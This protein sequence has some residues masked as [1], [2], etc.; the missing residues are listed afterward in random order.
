MF[1]YKSLSLI[2]SCTRLS[3]VG[4]RAF[5]VTAAHVWNSLPDLSLTHLP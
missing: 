1:I 5:P 3:I 4:D 2:V